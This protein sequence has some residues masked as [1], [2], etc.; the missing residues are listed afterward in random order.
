MKD[1]R[2]YRILVTEEH[3]RK[4]IIFVD[5]KWD[6]FHLK[7]QNWYW[8]KAFER[9]SQAHLISSVPNTAGIKQSSNGRE[10]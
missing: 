4:K 8:K 6:F 5:I 10:N 2:E 3:K 7:M 9:T 1:V